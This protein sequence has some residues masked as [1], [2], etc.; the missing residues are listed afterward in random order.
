MCYMM[1]VVRRAAVDRHTNT[2]F[3]LLL[4]LVPD[5]LGQPPVEGDACQTAYLKS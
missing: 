2:F 5:H 4:P 1:Y 3:L